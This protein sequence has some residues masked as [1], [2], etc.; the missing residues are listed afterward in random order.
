MMA[1][2]AR[3]IPDIRHPAQL[4]RGRSSQSSVSFLL[5]IRTNRYSRKGISTLAAD[6]FPCQIRFRIKTDC[7]CRAP[8]KNRLITATARRKRLLDSVEKR[9]GYYKENE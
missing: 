2:N 9:L 5:L 7:V 6:A 4:A 8:A 3:P 1:E